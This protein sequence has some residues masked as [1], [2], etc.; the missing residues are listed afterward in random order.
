MGRHYGRR[1]LRRG[2]RALKGRHFILC[3]A[4][5]SI[6]EDK[7]NILSNVFFVVNRNIINFLL[8]IK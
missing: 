3:N 8:R 2:Q 5:V 4:G 1:I 6:C 7:D